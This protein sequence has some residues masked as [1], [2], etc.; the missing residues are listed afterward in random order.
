MRCIG[1]LL[2]QV[3][4]RADVVGDAPGHALVAS[5]HDGRHADIGHARHVE[6]VAAKVHLIPARD[7][8][9]GDVRIARQEGSAGAAMPACHDPV[10]AAR[11]FRIAGGLAD[12]F[13]RPARQFLPRIAAQL[14][15]Q[16]CIRFGWNDGLVVRFAQQK[17][18]VERTVPQ[19]A[20]R[21]LRHDDDRKAS[22]EIPAEFVFDG[23]R[24][25]RRP[26][27]GAIVQQVELDRQ[28][29]AAL[30]D[31]GIDARRERI[32]E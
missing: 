2:I 4:Q 24:I 31:P 15:L 1:S 25:Q 21:Q 22:R 5:E 18:A 23:Q 26:R 10:V 29:F 17:L 11:A 32:P 16:R 14:L 3:P 30:L 28:A 6:T 9:D 8:L 7:G 20:L 12:I 19:H 27:L 13:A